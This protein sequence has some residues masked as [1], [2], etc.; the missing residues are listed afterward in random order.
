MNTP[1]C[2]YV[3]EYAQKAPAR[4][5]MPGH[6][7]VSFLGFEDRDITEISGADDLFHPSGI[8]AVC[9]LREID[10]DNSIPPLVSYDNYLTREEKSARI[11]RYFRKKRVLQC[12]SSVE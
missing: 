1:I 7:G 11:C 9:L 6:K 2:D 12:L 4:F 5:H 8:M 10:S 3:N